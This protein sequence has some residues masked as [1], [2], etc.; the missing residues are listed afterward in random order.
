M[1]KKF[2]NFLLEI[3]KLPIEE[4]A[5]ALAVE[6]DEWKGEQPQMDDVLVIGFNLDT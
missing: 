5:V 4:Q 2:R 3:H 6:L 1:A